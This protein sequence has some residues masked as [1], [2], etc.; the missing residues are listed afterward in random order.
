MKRREVSPLAGRRLSLETRAK[1]SAVRKGR[2][3]TPAHCAN[4]SAGLRRRYQSPEA[5]AVTSASLVGNRNWFGKH[6]S[7]KTKL[8][9]SMALKGRP[10]SPEHRGALSQA[11][12]AS[13]RAA[14]QMVALHASQK[15]PGSPRW[16]G[17]IA[18]LPYPWTFNAVLKE[19]I[20]QRDGYR[21]QVCRRPQVECQGTLTVHHIDYDKT[22]SDET[23]LISLC[24]RCHTKTNI[25]RSF[26]TLLFRRSSCVAT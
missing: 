7:A 14:A 11:R 12:R 22:N 16:L 13:A 15:G 17:G 6:H 8:A 1:M 5:R 25:N 26:W 4:I 20:R 23:N 24:R 3:F 21:C 18:R 9:I 2:S 10:F 19:K